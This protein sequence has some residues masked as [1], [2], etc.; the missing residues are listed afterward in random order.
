[1]N[2]VLPLLPTTMVGAYPRPSWF[3]QQLD[4]RDVREAFKSLHHEE[5]FRDA[6]R[7]VVGEQQEA[8][9]DVC[10]DGQMWFDDYAMG[11]GAF[12]W[13]WFERVG[14]F[15]H[16]KLEHPA[17]SRT[18]GKDAFTLDESGGVAVRGPIERGPVR[19][20]ELYG[21]AAGVAQRPI[22]ACVG[23]GPLQL[24]TM[25]HFESGPVK[26]RF[27]LSA[28]LAD[29]FRA[30][31]ENLVA[32]GCRHVQLEDLG[33]WV[34]N[35]T[36]ADRDFEWVTSTVDRLF[37]G[38]DGGVERCWHFCLGNAWGSRAE[39]LT[40]GGYGN[41]LPR[42][43]DVDVDAFV[44]DF[45]CRDMADVGVLADLP[46]DKGVHAGVIDV[47]N[48]EVE[49]PDQVA[50]RIRAVLAVIGAERV[51]LTTD[52]GMKQLPRTVARAKLRSLAAGAAIVRGEL[53]GER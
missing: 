19:L 41:V 8:G 22:K 47:R 49:Q 36:R 1:M 46:A 21:I 5:A 2:D 6:V 20:A 9:L 30:E 33:A 25:A 42:Y 29:V 32:A 11:I 28:A 34:P 38:L 15:G 13:Y 52:C 50:E 53:T 3:T 39:G 40:R 4:G 24:S 35:V 17:R 48:L 23:A 16:E 18:E 51:T 45:A 26:N 12:F 14:G 44:L 31:L 10:T 7:T 27:D 37:A 43:F